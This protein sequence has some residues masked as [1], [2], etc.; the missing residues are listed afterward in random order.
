MLV[1][2]PAYAETQGEKDARK[3]E[4]VKQAVN[5]LGTGEKARIK[6]RLKDGTRL[7]GYVGE[8]GADDFQIRDAKTATTN[9]VAYAQVKQVEGQNLST[10]AKV[11]IGLGIA[12]GVLVIVFLIG[13][14]EVRNSF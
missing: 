3:A 14:H 13:L 9:R 2:A 12:A 8:I 1:V 7:K 10:G 6:V 11:A 5:K 4:K